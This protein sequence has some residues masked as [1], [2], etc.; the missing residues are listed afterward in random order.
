MYK[1]RLTRA[2]EQDLEDIW[3]YTRSEW[4]E[5]QA[6]HYLELIDNPTI[7]KARPDIKIGYRALQ[8]QKHIIFYCLN[9]EFIDVIGILHGRMDAKRHLD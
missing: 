7:G 6:N 5:I 1:I 9:A 8:V 4:G 3:L 2:A